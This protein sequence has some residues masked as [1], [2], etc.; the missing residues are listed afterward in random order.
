MAQRVRCSTRDLGSSDDLTGSHGIS[1]D[2]TDGGI[3]PLWWQWHSL[4][5]I[6]CP[7]LVHVCAFSQNKSTLNKHTYTLLK[8]RKW[9]F[10]VKIFNDYSC[11]YTCFLSFS[12]PPLPIYPLPPLS[13]HLFPSSFTNSS[14]QRCNHLSSRFY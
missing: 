13:F 4:L 14:K 5:G 11:D 3:K 2:L 6:L 8:K 12:F 1:R 7:A 10:Q 9:E